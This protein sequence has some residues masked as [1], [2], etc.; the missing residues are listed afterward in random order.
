MDKDDILEKFAG[1][2]LNTLQSILDEDV[3]KGVLNEAMIWAASQPDASEILDSIIAR[4]ADIKGSKGSEAL[5]MACDFLRL[6][7]VETLL[8]SGAPLNGSDEN[9]CTAMHFV[10][11][12]DIMI[13]KNVYQLIFDHASEPCTFDGRFYPEHYKIIKLLL[14]NGADAMA[15]DCEGVSPLFQMLRSSVIDDDVEAVEYLAGKLIEKKHTMNLGNDLFM[16]LHD[17]AKGN[18]SDAMIKILDSNSNVLS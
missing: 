16:E 17:I 18:E 9:G 12:Q 6:E 3:D 15:L 14:E 4:G 13:C 11:D 2:E 1:A 8:N 5:I 7:N 10:C